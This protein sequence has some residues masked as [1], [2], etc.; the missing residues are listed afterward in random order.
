MFLRCYHFMHIFYF[1]KVQCLQN[2]IRLYLETS[3]EVGLEAITY[4]SKH[5]LFFSHYYQ[6]SPEHFQKQIL[7]LKSGFSVYVTSLMNKSGFSFRFWSGSGCGGATAAAGTCAGDQAALIC[8][9]Q[10]PVG[11]EER[12]NFPLER[13]SNRHLRICR[14]ISLFPLL[15][16]QG[17]GTR[18]RGIFHLLGQLWV[19][20]SW[21]SRAHS[22]SHTHT[23][24]QMKVKL[25]SVIQPTHHPRTRS[26]VLMS[27]CSFHPAA[28]HWS[29]MY[30]L[31]GG[32]DWHPQLSDIRGPISRSSL[33]CRQKV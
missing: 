5:K 15:S 27:L 20:C 18:R 4:S 24:T 1:K 33:H 30:G 21:Q 31:M 13:R 9:R 29:I 2:I 19:V 23:H 8:T 7:S 6:H 10:R 11:R 26:G 17:S 16:S 28:R 32:F 22:L 12:I 25:K 3:F 14:G